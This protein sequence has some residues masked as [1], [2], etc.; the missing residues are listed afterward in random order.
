MQTICKIKAT[1]R[2]N[3]GILLL[4]QVSDTHY[5]FH[6]KPSSSSIIVQ[7]VGGQILGLVF[8]LEDTILKDH[9]L[10][11][12][13]SKEETCNLNEGF[14][15]H[16]FPWQFAIV[17]A[18]EWD[19]LQEAYAHSRSLI[20]TSLRLNSFFRDVY[21]SGVY[22]EKGMIEN[23]QTPDL[24]NVLEKVNATSSLTN[25]T[26]PSF[27]CFCSPDD[28]KPVEV[29]RSKCAKQRRHQETILPK[30]MKQSEKKIYCIYCKDKFIDHK[31]R[32]YIIHPY[33]PQTFHGEDLYL[34][35]ICA[36]NW[37]D[38]RD[39]AEIEKM[40]IVEDEPNEDLCSVCSDTPLQL[41]LC[42][43]C[44]RSFC[45]ACL[46][47]ILRKGQFNELNN[48]DDWKCM[49]CLSSVGIHPL[50]K[51]SWRPIQ[52]HG[53]ESEFIGVH[54]ST[55]NCILDA[56]NDF[57]ID[58]EEDGDGFKESSRISNFYGLEL[59]AAPLVSPDGRKLEKPQIA[60]GMKSDAILKSSSPRKPSAATAYIH[61]PSEDSARSRFV[62]SINFSDGD[63][64]RNTSE[65]EGACDVKVVANN[66]Q[67]H[68]NSIRRKGK[69]EDTAPS[70]S[71]TA[72]AT[73][74]NA[75]VR[76]HVDYSNTLP[77]VNT[78]LDEVYYFSQYV[79]YYRDLTLQ[80]QRDSKFPF[81]TDDICFLC[82]DGGDLIECDFMGT[83]KCAKHRKCRK[84]YHDYCLSYA[85]KH[86]EDWKCP[87]HFCD[88][89]GT[90]EI[91]FA[92]LYCPVSVCEV[93]TEVAD[94][95]FGYAEYIELDK[96]STNELYLRSRQVI[97]I[98][99]H[100]CIINFKKCHLRDGNTAIF[101]DILSKPRR[102]YNVKP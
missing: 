25:W 69:R 53:E 33:V 74:V 89:C 32:E 3:S 63:R 42:C 95:Q 22:N 19:L 11:R 47:K 61:Q 100:N 98:A 9:S 84:V 15:G 29:D 88:I 20:R 91:K 31:I 85:V 76:T 46:K 26:L 52:I 1:F 16:D 55:G 81:N 62:Q 99:C 38:Y 36:N 27:G 90:V 21:F 48:E 39:K 77:P 87:R 17:D 4:F 18:F 13:K 102:T 45:H 73:H 60:Y 57:S 2:E 28:I 35:I 23:S 8:D 44:P 66:D 79:H 94:T 7:G 64:D 70:K 71:V 93:C 96:P 5:I 30:K 59:V 34:C 83:Q 92:C 82:K 43:T 50:P 75:G 86:D 101:E 51:K 24:I 10:W 41:V 78:E 6:F 58:F 65:R 67:E 97:S 14:L 72:S 49:A 40:L 37:K 54:A 12:N 80:C 68:P 56:N